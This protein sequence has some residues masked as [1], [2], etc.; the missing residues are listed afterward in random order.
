MEIIVKVKKS[1]F[2]FEDFYRIVIL[3]RGILS[4]FESRSK[5]SKFLDR[6]LREN[7]EKLKIFMKIL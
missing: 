5:N 7:I 6:G 3:A 2:P 4:K 1:S